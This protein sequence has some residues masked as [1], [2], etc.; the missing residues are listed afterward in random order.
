MSHFN[1][2][3]WEQMR[4]RRENLAAAMH[5]ASDAWH[6]AKYTFDRSF[7]VFQSDF[8]N[9]SG[10]DKTGPHLFDV[11]RGDARSSLADLDKFILQLQVDWPAASK[12]LNVPENF[13]GKPHVISVYKLLR[14]TTRLFE[15][16]EQSADEWRNYSKCFNVLDEFAAKFNMHDKTRNDPMFVKPDPSYS[17]EHF[18]PE[19]N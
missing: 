7:G 17:R 8:Q 13:I 14:D 9:K 15:A 12:R 11:I 4:Q 6:D 1:F 16:S 2:A 19:G 18:F 5:N 3:K 10:L